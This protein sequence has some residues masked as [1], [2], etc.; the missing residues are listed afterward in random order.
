MALALAKRRRCSPLRPRNISVPSYRPLH[1]GGSTQRVRPLGPG[2]G[3]GQHAWTGSAAR[4][5]SRAGADV[6]SQAKG[7]GPKSLC[8]PTRSLTQGDDQRTTCQAEPML[9]Q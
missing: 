5:I 2:S 8:A 3:E 6:Q 4:R 1:S 9:V 7:A